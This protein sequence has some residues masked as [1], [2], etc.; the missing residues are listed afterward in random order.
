MP[1]FVLKQMEWTNPKPVYQI[2]VYTLFVE[3]LFHEQTYF[4]GE[5]T[6]RVP[7]ELNIDKVI[8]ELSV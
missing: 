6:K 7:R 5:S 1:N 8:A 4:K 2:E 3:T